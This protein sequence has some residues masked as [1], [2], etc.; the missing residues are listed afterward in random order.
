MLSILTTA[1][2]SAITRLLVPLAVCP[3]APPGAQ[4]QLDKL[5][6]YVLWGVIA[7]FVV[8]VAVSIGAIV[9]GRVFH[10]QHA[11][12]AGVVGIVVVILAAI[13]YVTMPSV[14][15]GILGTGC[16]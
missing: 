9:A 13:A 5:T 14:V 16:I 8:G 1:Q 2:T 7:L 11:S 15:S 12:K 6:G 10:M 4:T 3:L